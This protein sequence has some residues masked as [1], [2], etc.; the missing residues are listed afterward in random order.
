MAGSKFNIRFKVNRYTTMCMHR[1]LEII[2]LT[3]ATPFWSKFLFP[4]PADVEKSSFESA[5]EIVTFFNPLIG[6]NE[7]QK[8]AVR[9]IVWFRMAGNLNFCFRMAENLC[10]IVLSSKIF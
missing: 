2:S 9:L 1:A 7:E 8:N 3:V 10:K 6:Q 5:E 4:T